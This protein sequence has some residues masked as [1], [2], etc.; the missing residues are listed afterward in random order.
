MTSRFV[1]AGLACLA[2]PGCALY[3]P[4]AGNP[5]GDAYLGARGSTYEASVNPGQTVGQVAYNP[6]APLPPTA[7]TTMS[8]GAP[9]VA[10]P[11][12]PARPAPR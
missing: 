4:S 3:A 9:L 7:D 11:P 2:L 6:S 8:N 12:P 10:P 5:N 1:L